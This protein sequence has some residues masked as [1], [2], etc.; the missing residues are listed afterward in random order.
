M[1]FLFKHQLLLILSWVKYFPFSIQR[2]QEDKRALAAQ[3][4][5]ASSHYLPAKPAIK[6]Y[7][8]CVSGNHLQ[9]FRFVIAMKV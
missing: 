2:S 5:H 7:G 8:I 4:W 1:R 9:V 3:S 6:K